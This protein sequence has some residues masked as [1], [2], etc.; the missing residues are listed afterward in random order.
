M[1]RP[2]RLVESPDPERLARILEG[3]LVVSST[4]LSEEE[5]AAATGE[6]AA[7]VGEAIA[8]LEQRHAEGCSGIV[9]EQVAGGYAYRAAAE[10]AEACGRLFE[11]PAGR[12][13][14]QAALET[15]AVIAYL[16][17]CTRP[18]IARIR[19]VNVDGVVAGLLDRGMI[20][21]DGRDELIGAVR[22]RTTALFERVFNLGSLAELPRL[23]DLA[24]D[25]EE[26]RERLEAIATRRGA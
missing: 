10:A 25:A 20:A 5:L 14:S 4:P 6:S 12:G 22:Y 15:L 26:L 17:P 2:L 7:Q 8:L 19:G 11:R 9:L 3:V 24:A 18:E 1:D 21:E 13:L 23:D 16:A